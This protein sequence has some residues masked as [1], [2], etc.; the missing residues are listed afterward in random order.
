MSDC[1]QVH[2]N[3]MSK[4]TLRFDPKETPTLDFSTLV[5]EGLCGAPAQ[6]LRLKFR[7]ASPDP[8]T[9]RRVIHQIPIDQE[10]SRDTTFARAEIILSHSPLFQ[11]IPQLQKTLRVTGNQHQSRGFPI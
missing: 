9:I 4:R 10:R 8:P 2:T 5:N 11:R 7:T 6:A 3:L 1:R